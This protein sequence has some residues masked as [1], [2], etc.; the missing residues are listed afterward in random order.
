MATLINCMLPLSVMITVV[1]VLMTVAYIAS[2]A[3][4]AVMIQRE[5]QSKL[6]QLL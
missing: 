4:F 6:L 3:I 5:L 1:L 2:T